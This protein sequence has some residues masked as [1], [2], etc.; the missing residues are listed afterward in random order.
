M[1]GQRDP[2][3]IGPDHRP[4]LHML[5]TLTMHQVETAAFTSIPFKAPNR[6]VLGSDLFAFYLNLQH[7][8]CNQHGQQDFLV[9]L[10]VSIT[11]HNYSHYLYFEVCPCQY[12]GLRVHLAV[13]QQTFALM[14]PVAWSP[15][16]EAD[17]LGVLVAIQIVG[18]IPCLR[19]EPAPTG[20]TWSTSCCSS[21]SREDSLLHLLLQPRSC[22][23]GPDMNQQLLQ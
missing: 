15:T 9:M 23:N 12:C 8:A 5:Y 16:L 2:A 13:W 3:V 19:Q 22:I 6:T 4:F 1:K 20:C 11:C 10:A 14:G 21:H 7:L 17:M 18:P